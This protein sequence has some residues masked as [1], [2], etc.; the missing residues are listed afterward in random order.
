MSA[1]DG[2]DGRVRVARKQAAAGTM[3]L[4]ASASEQGRPAR[5]PLPLRLL[6]QGLSLAI[7]SRPG[8]WRL[9]RRPT[10]RFWERSA[11]SWDQRI[12]PDRAE[13]LAPLSDACDRLDAEPQSILELGTG[14]GAGSRMLVRRFPA[15]RIRAIDLSSEMIDVARRNVP[16]ELADRIELEVAD[17]ASLPYEDQTFD[18]VAQLNMPVYLGEAARVLRPGGH[19]IVASS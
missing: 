1:W 12:E 3:I 17:A 9:L 8:V 13:H 16:P 11:V 14:T 15:A 10:Q 2:R 18:L 19:L 5:P 4:S 6:G 7:A